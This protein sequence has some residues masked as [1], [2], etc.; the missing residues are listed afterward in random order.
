MLQVSP[1]HTPVTTRHTRGPP[2][3][4]LAMRPIHALLFSPRSERRDDLLSNLD[5][6]TLRHLVLRLGGTRR[7]KSCR[8]VHKRQTTFG[9][10]VTA[11]DPAKLEQLE[12]KIAP[13]CL[14]STTSGPIRGQPLR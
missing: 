4:S 8:L 9:P 5:G 1:S 12:A 2:H 6:L 14:D 10:T 11:D 7:E 13:N 3:V